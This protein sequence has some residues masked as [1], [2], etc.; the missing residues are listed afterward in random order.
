MEKIST[1][2]FEDVIMKKEDLDLLTKVESLKQFLYVIRSAPKV[3]IPSRKNSELFR[4][5]FDAWVN[6]SEDIC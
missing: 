1:Y 2:Y 3:F 6:V 4:V 5:S